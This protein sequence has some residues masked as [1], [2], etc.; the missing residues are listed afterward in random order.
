MGFLGGSNRKN[1]HATWE[2]WVRSLSWEDTLEEGMEMHS[3][4][5]AQQIPIDRGAWRATVYGVAKSET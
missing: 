2:I 3:S 1:P 5:L 4:I